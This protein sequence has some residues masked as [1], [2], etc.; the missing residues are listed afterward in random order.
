MPDI[1]VQVTDGAWHGDSEDPQSMTRRVAGA[2]ETCLGQSL[3]GRGLTVRFASD[4]E[5]R[6]FNARF[7]GQD[8]PT[9][10]LAFPGSVVPGQD[11]APLGDVILA[12]ETI[13]R[14]AGEQ[15]K[16]IA[17][18][19]CHM[20]LH[21]ILHL[22]GYDHD[23]D[24]KAVKMEAAERAVLAALGIDDPYKDRLE[25]EAGHGA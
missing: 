4:A 7:R 9:N 13:A 12:R 10:V 24:D 18:H 22:L 21:G 11:G 16:S 23:T 3:N 5:V 15:G 20:I 25:A 17:A 2:L 8:A 14:E 19:S 1:D 6:G